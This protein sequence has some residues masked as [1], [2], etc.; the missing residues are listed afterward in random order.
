MGLIWLRSRGVRRLLRLGLKGAEIADTLAPC[1]C[2]VC[3][4]RD[5]SWPDPT[6]EMLE[7]PDFNAIWEA[8][9]TWDISVPE[10]YGNL[11]S[12][13]TGNH[14]RRILDALKEVDKLNASEALYAFGAWLTTRDESI[15]MSGHD[16]AAP[17]AE[18]IALFCEENNLADPR[19]GWEHNISFPE[20]IGKRIGMIAGM[21]AVEKFEMLPLPPDKLLKAR[22]AVARLAE[23]ARG[24]PKADSTNVEIKLPGHLVKELQELPETGMG[25]QVVN[26]RL[27]DGTVLRDITVRNSS[28]AFLKED[29][30]VHEI[31]EVG[32]SR[33]S[34]WT[35]IDRMTESDDTQELVDMFLMDPTVVDEPYPTVRPTYYPAKPRARDRNRDSFFK[36][37]LETNP[38]VEIGTA[39][40]IRAMAKI[41]RLILADYFDI[42]ENKIY[43]L[44]HS[45]PAKNLDSILSRGLVPGPPH[46]GENPSKPWLKNI[47]WMADDPTVAKHH[48]QKQM[49]KKGVPGELVVLEIRFDPKELTLYKAMARGFYT[50]DEVIPPGWIKVYEK[51]KVK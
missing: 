1:N 40:G 33:R 20:Q 39:R 45:T 47:V 42:D 17:V 29:V 13:A 44:Y 36:T 23:R 34:Y 8:I 6:P 9:K 19:P 43:T 26:F 10:V 11:Y 14:V 30:D 22:E 12:G 46:E 50:T 31:I 16:D 38:R 37:R 28:M 21:M 35:G 4:D 7:D 49:E 3:Q 32:M 15:T 2:G 5:S 48:G 25:Y 18:A 51:A 24:N 41:V 27:R